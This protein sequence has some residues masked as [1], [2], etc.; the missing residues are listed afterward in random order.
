M[1]GVKPPKF[2]VNKLTEKIQNQHVLPKMTPTI[3]R[4]QESLRQ[5]TLIPISKSR[6]VQS[7]RHVNHLRG[8]QVPKIKMG[9]EASLLSLH[10]NHLRGAQAQTKLVPYQ[11]HRQVR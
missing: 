7:T 11:N 4:P 5:A 1:P 10:V 2:A 3:H 6:L 8:A 9:K